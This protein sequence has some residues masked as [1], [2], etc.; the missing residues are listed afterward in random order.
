MNLPR[1]EICLLVT[2]LCILAGP[3]TPAMAQDPTPF[4][5]CRLGVGGLQY[6]VVGY[7]LG[8]LNMGLYLD[9]RARSAPPVGLPAEI[10]YLQMVRV[11]QVKDGSGWYGPPRVYSDPPAYHVS[12]DLATLANLAAAQPASLWLIGNE[13]ERVDWEEGTHWSG[14]DEMLPELYATAFH[15]IQAVINVDMVVHDSGAGG[16]WVSSMQEVSLPLRAALLEA[17]GTYGNGLGSA[18]GQGINDQLMFETAG[19]PACTLCEADPFDNAYIHTA[20]DS[21]D[22]P[23]YVDYTYA[24]QITRVVVGFLVDLAGVDVGLPNADHDGDGDVDADDFS[25]FESCFSGPDVAVDPPCDFFDL[26]E[27]GDVDCDDWILFEAVWTEPTYPPV[28]R[29]CIPALKRPLEMDVGNRCLMVSAPEHGWP[30]AL[31]LTGDLDDA[32]V[33]CLSLYV[34][35]DGSLA[36]A[37]VFQTFDAWGTLLVYEERIVPGTSYEVRCDYGEPGSPLLSPPLSVMTSRWGDTAGD[38]ADDEWALPDGTVDFDDISSLVD[39]FRH[40]PTAPLL[41]RAD[42]VGASSSRCIPN[43]NV[44]FLDISAAVDAF[45]GYDYWESTSCSAPCS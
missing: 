9:W 15:D 13:M 17:V 23:G 44:D 38:F 12:P 27:D 19:F 29:E 43:L 10:E 11:H 6:D 7:D 30:M 5:N 20:A 45:K 28:F 42:L 22:T 25:E 3:V 16:V 33:S 35:A 32:N 21:L 26:D 40:S 2:I 39:A 31:L 36:P 37:P 1:K 4:A 34:Q 41:H 24:A 8:Q 18:I 14:Q